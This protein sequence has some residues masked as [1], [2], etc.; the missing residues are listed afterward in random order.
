MKQSAL[1]LIILCIGLIAGY[2]VYPAV[3][4]Q[5]LLAD[6]LQNRIVSTQN[7]SIELSENQIKDLAEKIAPAV[8][9]HLVVSGVL[10]T[11]SDPQLA[12]KQQEAS[13]KIR[14][15]KETAFSQAQQSVDEMILGK[16]ITETGLNQAIQLLT[17]TGQ[18]DKV[19]LLHA[20]IAVAVNNGQLT[21]QQAGLDWADTP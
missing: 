15:D 8:A 18:G 21:P 9:E 20:R 19:Y 7:S 17:E 4:P 16:S 5:P 10:A 14:I 1:T 2:L 12:I 6:S 13:E 3:N 11:N